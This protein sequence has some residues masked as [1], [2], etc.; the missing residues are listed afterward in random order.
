ME[1]DKYFQIHSSLNKDMSES[2]V[3]ASQGAQT[4]SA[5]YGESLG[6]LVR[7]DDSKQQR[8]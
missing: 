6:K 5:K 4:P 2:D 3:W 8:G 1:I 7:S